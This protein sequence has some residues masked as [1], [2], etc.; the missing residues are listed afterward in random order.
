MLTTNGVLLISY[1][2]YTDWAHKL[3]GLRK[4]SEIETL[5]LF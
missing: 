2:A 3:I 4:L 5:N 1:R